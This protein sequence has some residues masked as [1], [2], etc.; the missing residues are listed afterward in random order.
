LSSR[1]LSLFQANLSLAQPLSFPLTYILSYLLSLTLTLLILT[2][3]RTDCLVIGINS[4]FL[5]DIHLALA[6]S[7]G[8]LRAQSNTVAQPNHVPRVPASVLAGCLP[9]AGVVLSLW[10]AGLLWRAARRTA[11]HHACRWWLL[12]HAPADIVPRAAPHDAL[13]ARAGYLW[14]VVAARR[15]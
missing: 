10:P 13:G 9:A 8:I 6:L 7:G 3:S 5:V 11:G 14:L 4:L 2:L 15:V 1:L 12:R